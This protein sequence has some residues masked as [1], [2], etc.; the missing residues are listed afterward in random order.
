VSE[1]E[2]RS[3]VELV[4]SQQSAVAWVTRHEG[5]WFGIVFVPDAERG[6]QV[7]TGMTK[8]VLKKMLCEIREETGLPLR[9]I[10]GVDGIAATDP[11]WDGSS[12]FFCANPACGEMHDIH[13]MTAA[14]IIRRVK[15]P[16]ASRPAKPGK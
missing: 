12:T 9:I 16:R 13:E 2:K 10:D 1:S 11:H 15:P 8:P 14:N 5:Q 7:L 4:H 3:I 6:L